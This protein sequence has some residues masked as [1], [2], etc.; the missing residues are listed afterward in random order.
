MSGV[1]LRVMVTTPSAHPEIAARARSDLGFEI[2]MRGLDSQTVA[3]LAAAEPGGYDLVQLEYWMVKQVLPSRALQGIPVSALRHF[4]DV[5]PLFVQGQVDGKR[6]SLEGTAPHTVQYLERPGSMAFADAARDYLSLAPTVCNSDTLGWRP[7]KAP[8]EVKSWADL[9]DPAFRGRVALADIP[10][11]GIVEAALA[12]EA[13]G[14]VKYADKGELTAAEIDATLEVLADARRGGQFHGLWQHYQ[15]SV[16][17]MADGPV[18]LESMWPPAVTALRA[19]RIPLRYRPL[20]EGARG[21]AGGFAL[22]AHLAG[23]KRDAALEYVNWYHSGWAGAFLTRQGYY[24]AV[25]ATARKHLSADEWGYW[26]EGAPA[27]GPIA[28]P[29]GEIIDPAGA[30]REGGSY[31]ERM[32]NIACWSSRMREEAYLQRRWAEV[33]H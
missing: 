22:A 17:F 20:Q 16:D 5:L 32:G 18:V 15:Q 10:S 26:Q 27:C 23:A 13:L 24:T 31:N 6:V 3:R 2:S 25:P 1:S 8:R 12:C 7:D 9:L 30:V 19:R 33:F 4:G 21:W 29:R 14:L 28:S 11:V